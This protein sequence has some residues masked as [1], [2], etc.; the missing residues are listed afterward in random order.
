MFKILNFTI[1]LFY[2]IQIQLNI[3]NKILDDYEIKSNLI[4]LM[5]TVTPQFDTYFIK[6]KIDIKTIKK[7]I[8]KTKDRYYNWIFFFSKFEDNNYFF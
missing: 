2:Y 1:D 5:K 3:Y 6:N 7:E 4:I 8:K